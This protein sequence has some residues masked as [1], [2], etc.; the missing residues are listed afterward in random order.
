MARNLSP[1]RTRSGKVFSSR[2]EVDFTRNNHP[3]PSYSFAERGQARSQSRVVF[4]NAGLVNVTELSSS[5]AMYGNTVPSSPRV[6][7]DDAENREEVAGSPPV[8]DDSSEDNRRE[9]E[10][11][12]VEVELFEPA[13]QVP[14][15]DDNQID[16]AEVLPRV[17]DLNESEEIQIIEENVDEHIRP[18]LHVE[19]VAPRPVRVLLR[20]S[21]AAPRGLLASA[22][23]PLIDLTDSPLKVQPPNLTA[24][25]PVRYSI[26]CPVCFESIST[27]SKKGYHFVSTMC[28]HIFCS[29]CLPK[30]LERS[31]QCPSCRVKLTDSGYHQLFL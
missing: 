27:V 30:C 11:A 5:T 29:Y 31:Q 21:P 15:L 17:G 12:A 24:S 20:S 7:V 18:L 14:F 25:S 3:Y 19:H 28:G 1:K 22:T 23:P 2:R 26:K 8:M 10:E 6:V 13:A 16:V 4:S 9:V